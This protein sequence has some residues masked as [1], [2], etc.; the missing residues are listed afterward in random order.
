M[1]LTSEHMLYYK[2]AFGQFLN[3]SRIALVIVYVT[4]KMPLASLSSSARREGRGSSPEVSLA[5]NLDNE[6][7]DIPQSTRSL[8]RITTVPAFNIHN[9]I[10]NQFCWH[11]T[12]L[13]AS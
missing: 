6:R 3:F 8:R 10:L 4:V 2:K 7:T 5:G 1:P 9:E 11:V 12:S 13:P